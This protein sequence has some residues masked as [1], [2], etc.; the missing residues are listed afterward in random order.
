[1]AI[2]YGQLHSNCLSVAAFLQQRGFDKGH[3]ACSVLENC[4]EFVPIFVGVTL[5][6][7]VFSGVGATFT[8]CK[9]LLKVYNMI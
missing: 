8:A 1:V 7:G 4:W 9:F 6:G 2:T 3:V 5:N